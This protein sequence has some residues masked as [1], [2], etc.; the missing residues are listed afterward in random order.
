[1]RIFFEEK[2]HYEYMKK[3][4]NFMMDEGSGVVELYIES[5][6]KTLQRLKLYEDYHSITKTLPFL[7]SINIKYPLVL[8]V[9]VL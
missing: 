9:R 4:L 5:L 8:F 1:M 2:H 7:I 3:M 6:C